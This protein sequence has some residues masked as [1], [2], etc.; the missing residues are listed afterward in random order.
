MAVVSPAAG[1][2]RAM[3]SSRGAAG[4]TAIVHATDLSKA[5]AGKSARVAPFTAVCALDGLAAKAPAG[6]PDTLHRDF[7]VPGDLYS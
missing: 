2:L 7:S 4:Q 6:L 3:S 1:V 5:M